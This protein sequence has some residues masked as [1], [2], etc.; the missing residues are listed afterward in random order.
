M[1]NLPSCRKE[2][3]L[4]G[5]VANGESSVEARDLRACNFTDMSILVETAPKI[6]D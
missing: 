5:T 3:N 6:E 1:V 4:D 2:D